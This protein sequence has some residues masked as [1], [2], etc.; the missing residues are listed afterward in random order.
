MTTLTIK[1]LKVRANRLQEATPCAKQMAA[2]AT[3][4]AS[5]STDDNRCA[6]TAQML[7]GCMQKGRPRKPKDLNMNFYLSRFSRQVLGR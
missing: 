1:K 2:L 6:Q 5:F 4:W 3:C 7:A